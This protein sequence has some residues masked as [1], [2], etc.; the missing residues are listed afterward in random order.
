MKTWFTSLN[1]AIALSAIAWLTEL[2][3]AWLDMMF[4]Y[5]GPILQAQKDNLITLVVTLIYT[6]IFAGWAYAMHVGLRESRS[7]LIT[8]FALNAFVWLAIPFGW[9][10]A[11]CTGDCVVR[12]GIF[13]NVGNWLNLIFGLLAGIALGLRV[14]HPRYSSSPRP[15]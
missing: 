2:W 1:G 5:P 7:A 4:E 12:A 10:T 6:A 3:R 15:A 14:W 11:Y 9:I 13:F 8:T